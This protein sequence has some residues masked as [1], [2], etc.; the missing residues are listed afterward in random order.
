[1]ETRILDLVSGV[2]RWNVT[3]SKSETVWSIETGGSLQFEVSNCKLVGMIRLHLP[4]KALREY[5]LY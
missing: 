2:E 4:R 5:R 3:P 1:M